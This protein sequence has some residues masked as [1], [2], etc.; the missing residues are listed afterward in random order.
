M[1][2]GSPEFNVRELERFFS[3]L[4][5]ILESFAQ[6]HHLRL[7]KYYH[8]APSWAFLFRHPSGGVG[9][10][11]VQRANE[12]AVCILSNWWYDDFDAAT[13][14]IRTTSVGPMPPNSELG[15]QLENALSELLSWRF[16]DWHERHMGYTNWRKTWT[17]EQFQRLLAEYPEP[18]P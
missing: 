14:F 2:N 13:R 18:L 12:M 4:A 3:V 6:R 1:P 16:G 8:Q 17:K 11:E 7:E 10:L 5:A 15:V 9:K